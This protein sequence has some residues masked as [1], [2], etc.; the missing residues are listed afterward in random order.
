MSFRSRSLYCTAAFLGG[1]TI[2]IRAFFET[3]GEYILYITGLG[4]MVAAYWYDAAKKYQ[5]DRASRGR[6]SHPAWFFFWPLLATLL[7]IYV[8]TLR[9]GPD[10][11]G[12]MNFML[13]GLSNVVRGFS[14]LPTAMVFFAILFVGTPVAPTSHYAGSLATQI[15]LLT[16]TV[17][18]FVAALYGSGLDNSHQPDWISW[19]G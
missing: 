8:G 10:D 1:T 7:V 19:L 14:V 3:V 4:T 17:Y 6:N 5:D 9:V 16:A 11:Y 15:I 2:Q 13:I 18:A 12:R